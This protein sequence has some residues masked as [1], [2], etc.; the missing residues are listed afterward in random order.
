MKENDI[1]KLN[2]KIK[3]QTNDVQKLKKIV[4]FGESYIEFDH[5]IRVRESTQVGSTFSPKFLKH[6]L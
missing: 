5:H 2:L 3:H 6:S 1:T 4:T